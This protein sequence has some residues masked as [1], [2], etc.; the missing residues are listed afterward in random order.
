MYFYLAFVFIRFYQ[1][2]DTFER[3]LHWGR[4]KEGICKLTFYNNVVPIIHLCA[5][6]LNEIKWDDRLAYNNHHLL[7]DD[8]ITFI[9]DGFPQLVW[10]PVDPLMR[11]LLFVPD[12]YAAVVYKLY[13]TIDLV[14][15]VIRF[16]GLHL[17][18]T[19]DPLIWERTAGEHP[20]ERNEFGY[21]DLA[22]KGCDDIA[23][24]F[25]APAQ[26]GPITSFEDAHNKRMN[27]VRARV[28]H[29]VAEHVEGKQMFQGTYRGEPK[30]LEACHMLYAHA[31]RRARKLTGQKYESPG[32]KYGP[33]P[34]Y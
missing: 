32:A 8:F 21:G 18:T 4:H 22:Y 20:T 13:I 17:G 11:S 7:A 9:A 34:I 29:A 28:E 14:G 12:K 19:P 24:N 16:C 25:V 10:Q 3:W 1:P 23:T 31:N 6:N 30:L 2:V 26:Y 5:E 15:N 33:H 27:K